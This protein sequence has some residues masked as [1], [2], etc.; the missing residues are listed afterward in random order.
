MTTM[1]IDDLPAPAADVLRRRARAAG[2]STAA[3][4]REE[5]ISLARTRVP[6]DAVVEFLESERPN[7]PMPEI[8][9]E[10]MALI[11]T[12]DLPMDAWSTFRRRAAAARIP[13]T[14]YVR[15]ELLTVARRTTM[16]DV[17]LEFEELQQ[18]N[19]GLRL[20]MDAIIASARD[21]R[22]E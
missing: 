11:H 6:V 16:Q 20:D 21:A 3:L 4:I 15:Q 1:A 9:S 5:L 18:L 19:P 13:L 8:D 2:T 7:H 12:Y 22:A 14:A 10:A 17:I